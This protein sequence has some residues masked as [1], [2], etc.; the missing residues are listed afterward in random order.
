MF[1]NDRE[2]SNNVPMSLN[3]CVVLFAIELNLIL[4]SDAM[5]KDVNIIIAST[6][7]HYVPMVSVSPWNQ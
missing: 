5:K 1:K 4:L 2:D 3:V 6:S 7:L